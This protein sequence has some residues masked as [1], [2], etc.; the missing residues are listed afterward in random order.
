M[1]S[2]HNGLNGELYTSL[3]ECAEAIA[4]SRSELPQVKP[5][6]LA[7]PLRSE[8]KTSQMICVLRGL[9]DRAAR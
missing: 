3:L 8:E 5:V 2:T 9:A 7:S 1:T 6:L 4:E